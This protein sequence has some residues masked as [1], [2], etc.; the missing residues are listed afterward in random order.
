MRSRSACVTPSRRPLFTVFS[1]PLPAH[2]CAARSDILNTIRKIQT[3]WRLFQILR[4]AQIYADLDS[5]SQLHHANGSFACFRGKFVRFLHGGSILSGISASSKPGAIQ[6][7]IVESPRAV[8]VL[9]QKVLS[10]VIHNTLIP[11]LGDKRCRG[12]IL[13]VIGWSVA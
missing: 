6:S 7:C 9:L 12:D 3:G 11:L 5:R 2:H 8:V 1:S 10:L 4:C 13:D